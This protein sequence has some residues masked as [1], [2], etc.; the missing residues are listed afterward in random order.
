MN[1]LNQ[2]LSDRQLQEQA[3]ATRGTDNN[4]IIPD[5][6]LWGYL[7]PIGKSE[8]MASSFFDFSRARRGYTVT[9]MVP[10]VIGRYGRRIM[11]TLS[12]ISILF[13]R[14]LIERNSRT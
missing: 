9:V 4:F 2:L 12:D 3:L 1:F 6:T 10:L 14:V 13:W 8:D 11:G 7:Q 5:S